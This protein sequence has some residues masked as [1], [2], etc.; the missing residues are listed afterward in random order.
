MSFC[1]HYN[2]DKVSTVICCHTFSFQEYT[3]WLYFNG[4]EYELR[5]PYHYYTDGLEIVIFKQSTKE[6]Q[7]L[8]S[9]FMTYIFPVIRDRNT[10]KYNLVIY[11]K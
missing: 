6:K 11:N 2:I 3:K 7:R 9:Y 4:I 8:L 10:I 1:H 5:E